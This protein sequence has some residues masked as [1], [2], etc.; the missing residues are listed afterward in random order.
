MENSS[1]LSPSCLSPLYF[2][3]YSLP[4]L[5]FIP[6]MS[7]LCQRPCTCFYLS[8]DFQWVSQKQEDRSIT[9][10]YSSSM[11]QLLHVLIPGKAQSRC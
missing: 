8:L 9:L 5:S 6:Q 10:H 11:Q 2:H 3:V 7:I 1:W 4:N